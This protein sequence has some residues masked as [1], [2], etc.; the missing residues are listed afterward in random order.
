MSFIA[1]S[2]RL[3]VTTV[4]IFLLVFFFSKLGHC[5]T[6][7][8]RSLS[9]CRKGRCRVITKDS[10]FAISKHMP[11]IECIVTIANNILYV[12]CHL[13]VVLNLLCVLNKELILEELSEDKLR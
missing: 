6:L 7:L 10:L 2:A 13:S 3:E 5:H 4:F 1:V 8:C 11:L 12:S 9:W